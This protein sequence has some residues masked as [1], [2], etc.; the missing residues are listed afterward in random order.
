MKIVCSECG[1]I[2]PGS[3]HE[4]DL[5]ALIRKS[6]MNAVTLTGSDNENN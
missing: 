6:L 3:N 4:C 1:E 5:S 2:N